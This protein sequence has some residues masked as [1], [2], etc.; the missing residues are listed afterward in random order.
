MG[1][2]GV[3]GTIKVIKTPHGEAPD[4]VRA[5]F[6]G[7][8]LP[9]YSV[10]GSCTVFSALSGKEERFVAYTVPQADALKI[11]E[12]ANPDAAAWWR[13][14]GYPRTDRGSF[15]FRLDEVEVISGVHIQPVTLV[16]DEMQG[17]PGR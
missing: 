9:C 8:V 2:P 4:W 10:A 12:A 11:L 17:D 3:T 16:T 15:A 7:L 6:V 13:E 14:H 1:T 5:V